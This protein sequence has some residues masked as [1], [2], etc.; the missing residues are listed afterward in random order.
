L[1]PKKDHKYRLYRNVYHHSMGYTV[2]ILVIINIFK[3]VDV[4]L[5]DILSRNGKTRLCKINLK[6]EHD[7]FLDWFGPSEE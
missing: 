4:V 3:G 1:R 5:S 7:E 2:I 6:E